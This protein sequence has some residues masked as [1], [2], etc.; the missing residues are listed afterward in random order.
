VI[1]VGP[2]QTGVRIEFNIN[3]NVHCCCGMESATNKDRYI[4]ILYATQT[5]TA[6]D[7][8]E[9]IARQLGRYHFRTQ[10]ASIDTYDIVRNYL[11]HLLLMYSINASPLLN[12]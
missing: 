9:D 8:A 12:M 10:V 7:V 11:D 3:F 6:K 5:G 4:L 2:G 1:I